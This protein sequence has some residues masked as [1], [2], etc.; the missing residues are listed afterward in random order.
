MSDRRTMVCRLGLH[1]R[2]VLL[3]TVLSAMAPAAYAQGPA[4]AAA[5][6]PRQVE[7]LL[8]AHLNAIGMNFRKIP[9]GRF[10]LG[11]TP[12]AIKA[13]REEIERFH[14]KHEG[15]T[16]Q[17]LLD[18]L[19]KAKA[20]DERK[21]VSVDKA[22]WM[23][24]VET[25]VSDYRKFMEATGRPEPA[26]ALFL[27][28]NKYWTADWKPLRDP[29]YNID[30]SPVCCVSWGDAIAFCQWLSKK[31]GRKYRLPTDME[32]EYAAKAGA[33]R[34]FH[35]SDKADPQLMNFGLGQKRPVP[36]GEWMPVTENEHRVDYPAN[37]FGLYH[38]LG[39]V[40]EFVV[41]TI[42]IEPMNEPPGYTVLPGYVN[43]QIRGG[44]WLHESFDC[45]ASRLAWN[46]PP[47]SNC[48]MGFRVVLEDEGIRPKPA[49]P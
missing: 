16:P 46:C 30:E 28:G 18:A 31:E 32:W 17:P 38:M 22:F 6:K 27:P 12:P 8:P 34:D 26:G 39:N 3:V 36:T 41:T 25:R 14:K 4:G 44:S 9:P 45:T 48:S 11:P 33:D 5:E 10:R 29:A 24:E 20:A 1:V 2:G 15:E 23:C 37:A 43:R 49:K 42:K 21:V 13:A 47:R 19:E 7:C 35:F 40:Q